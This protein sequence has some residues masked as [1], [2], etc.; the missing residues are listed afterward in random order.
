MIES[1]YDSPGGPKD[2]YNKGNA[3]GAAAPPYVNDLEAQEEAEREGREQ[4]RRNMDPPLQPRPL[5]VTAPIGPPQTGMHEISEAE[6][7]ASNR[8]TQEKEARERYLE[9]HKDWEDELKRTTSE[10]VD[11]TPFVD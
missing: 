9:L 8:Y 11:P 7:E 1:H 6:E 3:E 2:S 4:S 5:D 10:D